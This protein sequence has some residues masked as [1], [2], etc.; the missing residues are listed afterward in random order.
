MT[1]VLALF[2]FGHGGGVVIVFVLSFVV[3]FLGYLQ[4]DKA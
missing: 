1:N 2:R 4:K 3:L